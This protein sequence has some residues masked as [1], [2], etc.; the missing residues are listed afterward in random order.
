MLNC[1]KYCPSPSISFDLVIIDEAHYF[2]NIEGGSLRVNVAKQFFN[3]GKNKIAQQT[4]L[5]TA[6]PNHSS[7]QNINAITSYFDDNRYADKAYDAILEDICLRRFRRLSQKGKVKYN[8][9]KE[10]SRAAD[11]QD[12]PMPSYSLVSI[13]SNSSRNMS[14]ARCMEVNEIFL[15]EGTEFI[16]RDS[17]TE[18]E[19]KELKEGS[20]FSSG[21][22]G[23]CCL[24]YRPS[25]RRSLMAFPPRIQSMKPSTKTSSSLGNIDHSHE[26]KL[27]FVRRIPSCARLPQEQFIDT[28]RSYLLRLLRSWE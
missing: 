23:K 12:D 27:V 3:S 28:M 24:P 5:L 14:K 21:S 4:L 26:K 2:R 1:C 19:D 8:Y 25:I 6:T 10:V 16:P 20:D 11:F 15:A 22:D 7:S 9:R 13:K 17:S 18:E